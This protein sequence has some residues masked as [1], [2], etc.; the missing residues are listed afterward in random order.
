MVC[1]KYLLANT[2]V[3]F[4]LPVDLGN[5]GC[6]GAENLIYPPE[7]SSSIGGK[8]GNQK[9]KYCIDSNSLS[10]YFDLMMYCFNKCI[11]NKYIFVKFL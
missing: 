7:P 11:C 2:T 10:Y 1:I 6:A 8:R 9:D 5:P 4:L 3:C